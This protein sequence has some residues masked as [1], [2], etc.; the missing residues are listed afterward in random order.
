MADPGPLAGATWPEVAAADRRILLV[1]LG[2][3]EQHGPHLPLT[4][5]TVVASRLAELAH[6]TMP[7]VG[8]AP[9]IPYGASGEHAHF[10]GTLSIGTEALYQL[11]VEFVRHAAGDWRHV[12]VVN[13]HGGNAEA[14]ARA[15]TLTRYE[16]R[17]LQVHHA[18][19]GGPRADPHAG[20]RETCL[21]LHLAPE[22]VRTDLAA[23]GATAPRADL[24]PR[25]TAGGVRAVS[26]NGVLGDPTGANAGE[27]ARIFTAMA[28]RLLDRIR[29]LLAAP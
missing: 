26:A 1:P 20:Y 25:I 14:L 22:T 28:D 10:P 16:G 19:S 27:G 2:S 15:A 11:L 24:L 3:T 7:G 21:M 4:T 29:A 12:L 13:G 9:A 23:P 6:R 18:A 8:L 5:D 17:S